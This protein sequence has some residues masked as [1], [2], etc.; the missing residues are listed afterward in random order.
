M[1]SSRSQSVPRSVAHSQAAV[2]VWAEDRYFK[3]H[4]KFSQRSASF[5]STAPRF[6]QRKSSVVSD[7]SYD[8]NHVTGA[9]ARAQKRGLPSASMRSSSQRLSHHKSHSSAPPPGSYDVGQSKRP[10]TGHGFRSKSDR[11]GNWQKVPS[12]DTHYS[13]A[14]PKTPSVPSAAYRSGT[15]RI[16][17]Y[18]NKERS[19][20]PPPGA[21]DMTSYELGGKAQA[22]RGKGHT[23]TSDRFKTPKPN[24][25]GPGLYSLPSDFDAG[26]KK[27]GKYESWCHHALVLCIVYSMFWSYPLP[28]RATTRCDACDLQRYMNSTGDR[29]AFN[30]SRAQ[31]PD[32]GAYDMPDPLKKKSFNVKGYGS[33]VKTGSRLP[34]NKN[35]KLGPGMYELPGTMAGK[36]VPSFKRTSE[37]FPTP[38]SNTLGPGGSNPHIYSSFLS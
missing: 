12:H 20:S 21:Y 3:S 19:D 5:A 26:S 28:Y 27:Y 9:F 17:Y 1:S 38:K 16:S 2:D 35:D 30:K 32:P 13:Q 15:P 37:R 34:S 18:P 31:G 6:G 24:A 33:M 11:F 7:V 10:N 23:T 14:A 29:L 22:M 36:P 25:P 4:K 8:H